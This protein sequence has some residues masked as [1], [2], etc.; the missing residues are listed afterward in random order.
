MTGC[1]R[2]WTKSTIRLYLPN[3]RHA[4]NRL[5]LH[6]IPFK[7]PTFREPLSRICRRFVGVRARTHT[8]AHRFTKNRAGKSTQGAKFPTQIGRRALESN[9]NLPFARA[10]APHRRWNTHARGSSVCVCARVSHHQNL[11]SHE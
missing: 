9:R 2:P 10:T 4:G 7:S 8:H 3:N 6:P 11:I 1:N 5:T